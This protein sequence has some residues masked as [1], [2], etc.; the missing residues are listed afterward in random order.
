LAPDSSRVARLAPW[1][2][3]WAH[4]MGSESRQTIPRVVVFPDEPCFE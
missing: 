1:R 2:L 4:S 3:A